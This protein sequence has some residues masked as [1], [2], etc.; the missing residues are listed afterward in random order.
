MSTRVPKTMTGYFQ[1]CH[2]VVVIPLAW[3]EM[4]AFQHLNN[5]IYFRYF[6]T[7]RIAFFEKMKMTK[8][9]LPQGV[10]PILASTS[11]RFKAPLA[12]PDTL[13]VGVRILEIGA[14]RFKLEHL[15]VSEKLQKVAA[16]GE[17]V[18]VSYDYSAQAKTD[19]PESWRRRLEK[20]K[21]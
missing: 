6:E 15:V 19:L 4:D 10:G 12:Y 14:D 9:G 1:G 11:C 16:V 5:I 17:V 20:A 21:Q 18:V 2:T 3:G 13:Y 7:A 8:R